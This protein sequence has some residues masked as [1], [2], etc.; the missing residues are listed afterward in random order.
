M[1][2]QIV[3]LREY[4]FEDKKTGDKVEGFNLYLQ[5]YEDEVDG[6]CCEAISISKKKLEG[7][8]PALGDDV[9]VAYNQYKKADWI[10]KLAAV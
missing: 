1:A 4:S 5:W 7:Y 3:G 9:K 2:K 6:V 8:V 10:L